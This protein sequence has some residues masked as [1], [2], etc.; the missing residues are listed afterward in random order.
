MAGK[1]FQPECIGTFQSMVEDIGQIIAGLQTA[2]RELESNAKSLDKNQLT[3]TYSR[4][5][6]EEFAEGETELWATVSESYQE[7]LKE[8][9]ELLQSKQ[10]LLPNL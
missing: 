6:S 7:S 5:Q 9:S 2:I 3:L 4:D 8:L 1:C 10:E